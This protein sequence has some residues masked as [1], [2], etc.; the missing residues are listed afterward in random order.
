[1]NFA[2][3]WFV[4]ESI[5]RLAITVII[6]LAY[7]LWENDL[8]VNNFQVEILIEYF[9]WTNLNLECCFVC[10]PNICFNL[11]NLK[12]ILWFQAC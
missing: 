7:F 5:L 12:N 10:I 1:M 6:F 9:I 4:C 2:K 11:L 3:S 8:A